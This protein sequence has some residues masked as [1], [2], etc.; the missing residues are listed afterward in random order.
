MA[1]W[2]FDQF[3]SQVSNQVGVQGFSM[4]AMSGTWWTRM[5]PVADTNA[6]NV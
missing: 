2:I 5:A 3:I 1:R 4:T 6:I